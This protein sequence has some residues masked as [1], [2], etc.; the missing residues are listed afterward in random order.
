[1]QISSCSHRV[2]AAGYT[3]LRS[4][5][6]KAVGF[7]PA[8][9]RPVEQVVRTS[10]RFEPSCPIAYPNIELDILIC[11]SLNV[12]TNCGNCSHALIQLQFV[13]YSCANI[14]KSNFNKSCQSGTYLFFRLH[15]IPASA[16]SSPS[17]QTVL[18]K[19]VVSK[20]SRDSSEKKFVQKEESSTSI[21]DTEAVKSVRLAKS[22]RLELWPGG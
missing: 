22:N 5:G 12:E 19:R 17:S 2:R 21:F 10:M 14:N 16:T 9:Q 20:L 11:H 4:N 3:N 6:A 8:H 13:K 15:L 18:P 1:M 7:C